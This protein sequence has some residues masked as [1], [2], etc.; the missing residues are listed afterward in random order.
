V[1]RSLLSDPV[2]AVHV[3]GNLLSRLGGNRAF[4]A[5]AISEEF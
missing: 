4:R 3:L 1:W 2:Q 5:F